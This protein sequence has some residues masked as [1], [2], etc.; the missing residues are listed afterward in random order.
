MVL[1][2]VLFVLGLLMLVKGG[3]VFVEAASAIAKALRVPTFI[4]GATIVSIATTLPEMLVSCIAA[5]EGKNDMAI[6]NAVGSVTANT[7]LIMAIA[8]IF[9]AV[10]IKRK[11]YMK[12]CLML[13]AAALLVWLG[14]L[15]GQLTAWATVGLIALFITFMVLNIKN[16]KIET[17]GN[18]DQAPIEKT[19][20]IKNCVLFAVGAAAI[21]IGSQLLVNGGSDIAAMLGVPERIIAVTLVAV[22]T[23]LPELVTTLTAIRKK[24]SSLSIGNI[25]GANII[26]LSLILPACSLVSGK[27]LPVASL[28]LSLDFPICL[29]VILMAL[30]P[31]LL[32][33]KATKWQGAAMLVV[34]VAYL[35]MIIL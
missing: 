25:I 21:V 26:D 24:E 2:I 28:S 10:S 29:L 27:P 17:T 31:L 11:D 16:A 9:M 13:I 7:A 30:V 34:Y 6:G 12:Q 18:D 3:D 19:M 20:V 33:E 1:P 32:K 15:S 8:F 35:L 5:V 22:G 4:I 14:S 23:S